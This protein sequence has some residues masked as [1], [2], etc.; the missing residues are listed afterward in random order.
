MSVLLFIT[1]EVTRVRPD[2]MEKFVED[3]RGLVA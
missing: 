2:E 1:G 3:E